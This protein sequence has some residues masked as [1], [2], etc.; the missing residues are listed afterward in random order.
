MRY[1]W[2]EVSDSPSLVSHPTPD[3][4]GVTPDRARTCYLKSARQRLHYHHRNSMNKQDLVTWVDTERKHDLT[5]IFHSWVSANHKY[6]WNGIGKV[7]SSTTGGTLRQFE[8]FRRGE[9]PKLKDFRTDE[10]VEMLTSPEW[11][12]FCFVRNPY[13][14]LFSAYKSK[15]GDPNGDPNYLEE[16]EEMR[17]MFEY[18][19]RD[20]H[21]VGIVA[22]RDF[23]RYVHAG[24]R[25]YDGHWCPQVRRLAIEKISY[26][27]IGR[28]ETFQRDFKAL[29][30]RLG[31]PAEVVASAEKVH[32]QTAK[33]CLSA[34]YDRELADIVYAIYKDDFEAFDY[35]HDSWMFQ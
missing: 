25:W 9:E 17:E 11:C 30:V 29:L 15:I 5:E 34:V 4:T 7:A 18:P 1:P 21:R 22:F 3:C 32:G 31:A 28:F 13:D 33:I 16:Q 6:V 20:G 10:I 12:R 24:N 2:N 14:R 26:D 35:D 8:G 23:V 27:F 19:E